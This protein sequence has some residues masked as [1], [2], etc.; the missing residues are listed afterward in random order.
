MFKKNRKKRR[1][2]LF[3]IHSVHYISTCE[4]KMLAKIKII[5]MKMRFKVEMPLSW[6]Y[7]RLHYRVHNISR[8]YDVKL[9]IVQLYEVSPNTILKHLLGRRLMWHN[10]R[11]FIN[12]HQL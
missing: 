11:Q 10:E 7:M 2:S 1:I 6:W 4:S 12:D 3:G 5:F 9:R 8:Y